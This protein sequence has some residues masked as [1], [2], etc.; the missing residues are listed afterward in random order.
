MIQINTINHKNMF[1]SNSKA[2][3]FKCN[4]RLEVMYTYPRLCCDAKYQRN[5]DD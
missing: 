1:K 5:T 3:L 2:D 4:I